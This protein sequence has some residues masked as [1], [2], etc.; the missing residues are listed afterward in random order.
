ME[1]I[2]TR[3]APS[4]TGY[5]HV[6]NV[7]SALYP[8]LVAR[9]A[10]VNGDQNARFILRIEDT[11][12]TRFV[13][14]AE[15]LIVDTLRW[16]GL[17]WDEGPGASSNFA[18]NSVQT[19]V[20][21][22]V[23]EDVREIGKFG[24]YHQTARREIYY[25]YAQKLIDAGFAY[26]DTTSADDIASYRA[27]CER[28]GQPFLFRNI[29]PDNPPEWTPG[30][31]ERTTLPLRF[32]VKELKKYSWHDEVFGDLSA[33]AEVLD[34]FILIKSDGLPTYNFAHVVD[35]NEQHITHVIRGQEY[36]SSM[37]RYLAL[38][39]ALGIEWPIFAHLP[40]IM[41]PDGKKKLGKRDGAKSVAEYRA[42]GILPEAMLNFLALLGWNP[43]AGSE[44]EIFT[45]DDLVKQFDLS[46]VQKSGARFDENH[47]LWMNGAWIRKLSV[48]D[49]SKL[50]NDAT[51]FWGEGAKAATPEFR[52]QVLRVVA[53]RL[54][55]LRDLPSLTEYFFARPTPNWTMVDNNKQLRKM[56]RYEL[57]QL[58]ES[59]RDMLNNLTA[60]DFVNA[61]SVQS[62]LN[63]LLAATGQKPVILFSI[64]RFALTW[65]PFSP[66]LPETIA[67]LGK[68]ETI[69]RLDDAITT[70]L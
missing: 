26:A 35:D 47:L 15:D 3:F 28:S 9:Q 31:S 38:Y 46:H 42:D 24:P 63:E 8:Y 48:E 70:A 65:A 5:I 21:N 55:T 68:A 27:E 62:T 34:D 43:G 20:K 29:R 14:G 17:N 2:R 6:G 4:P 64:I 16:L 44:Q 53:D 50:S 45:I 23:G 33:G 66:G 41:R 51:Q 37:P 69:A 54:K 56:P 30:T 58:L 1:N 60:D 19:T 59:A 49:F 18:Q 67:T 36:I 52:N 10:F 61:D 40:H 39:D 57:K 7:R 12:Q 11:D 32:K 22:S 25:K 13:A